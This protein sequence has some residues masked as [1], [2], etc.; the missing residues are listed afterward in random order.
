MGRDILR[1]LGITLTAS[2]NTGKKV[3]QISDTPIESNIIK[4]T[5]KKYPKLCTQL[6]K[7]KNHIAKPTMKLQTNTAKRTQSTP[8]STR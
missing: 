6:G 5:L 4:W 1:K 2:K 3:L 7:S 8:P